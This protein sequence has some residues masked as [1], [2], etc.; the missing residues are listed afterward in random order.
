MTIRF[1]TTALFVLLF[2][3]KDKKQRSV[4]DADLT[5][6]EFIELIPQAKLPFIVYDSTLQKKENDSA[7][8]NLTVFQSFVPDSVFKQQYPSTKQ[9]KLFAL[10]KSTDAQKGNY[11]FIKSINSKRRAVYLYYFNEKNTYVGTAVLLDNISATKANRYTRIDSRY[12]I[13]L[14]KEQKTATG[15]LWTDETIYYMDANGKMILAMTNSTEDK[16]DE[17]MGNPI[18]TLPAKN[19]FS[20]DY[21]SDKKNMV[22]IRDGQLPKTFEFFIHFSKQNGECVGELKGEGEFTSP[23]KGVFHDKDSD[24]EIIF[25]FSSS[26]VT[27]KEI[28]GCGS[29]RGITCFFEGAYMKKKAAPKSKTLI[30]KK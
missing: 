28:N 24:C 17:I 30:K 13:A 20:A 6:K 25:S 15:E 16:S 26:S 7:A 23:G 11:I 18:D 12:N 27:I 21:A 4:V 22:S 1:V 29:Y 14:I 5:I 10:G 3:C 8:L 9:L 19:K 2:A